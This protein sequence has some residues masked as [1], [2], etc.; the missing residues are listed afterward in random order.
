MSPVGGVQIDVKHVSTPP[1]R[2]HRSVVELAGHVAFN[3]AFA[4]QAVGR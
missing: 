1:L 2:R 3:V 4:D